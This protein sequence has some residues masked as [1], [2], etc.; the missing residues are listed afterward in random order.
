M[1]RSKRADGD[2]NIRAMSLNLGGD[3]AAGY[4][5]IKTN[6]EDPFQTQYGHA[7]S[8]GLNILEPVFNPLIL[9]R[10]VEWSSILAQCVAAMVVNIDS[11]GYEL[12]PSFP[13]ADVESAAALEE[14]TYLKQF[15]DY[16]NP[17]ESFQNV[18]Q[19]IRRDIETDGN[20]YLEIVRDRVGRIVEGYCSRSP[21]MRM[22]TLDKDPVEYMESIPDGQGGFAEVPRRRRFRR[23]VQILPNA[24]KVYFKEFGDPRMISAATG[25]AVKTST[26]EATEIIHFRKDCSFSP[27]GIPCYAAELL[28]IMG[29]RRAQEL[30]YDTLKNFGI[31]RLAILVSGGQLTHDAI[32]DIKENIE[33]EIRAKGKQ[34]LILDAVPVKGIDH[35]GDEHFSTVKIDFKPLNE[36]IQQDAM[37]Q[38]Y[39]KNGTDSV[40][41]SFR[42]NRIV[43]GS[44]E[45][46]NFATALAGLRHAENHV[47]GPERKASDYT[48]NRTILTDLA[49]NFWKYRSLAPSTRDEVDVVKALTGMTDSL[50]I[51]EIRRPVSRM[52]GDTLEDLDLPTEYEGM[53]DV[54][55]GLISWYQQQPDGSVPEPTAKFIKGLIGIADTI[56]KRINEKC[57]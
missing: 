52:L 17:T 39:L 38:N 44:S 54:P 53:D 14:K 57:A 19:K 40:R 45:D 49:I 56:E 1:S 18:K 28:T 15:C 34:I 22:T 26:K 29:S 25:E 8:S 21:Y 5:V 20:G 4:E 12:L 41:A 42:L 31:P 50:T 27:Y 55:M 51:N 36:A 13:D 6:I 37:Y 3:L 9:A 47:F 48:I 24:K 32:R 46:Y 10:L 30:N 2:T 35:K 7:G 11:F 23:Y 16:C 43:T 33:N